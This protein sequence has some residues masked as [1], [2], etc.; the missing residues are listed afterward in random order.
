MQSDTIAA[1]STAF[2]EAAISL[3]RISGPLA[4]KVADEVFRSR[5]TLADLPARVQHFGSVVSPDGAVVDSVLATVFRGPAS[6]TGED[7]VEISCH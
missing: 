5:Q 2:G 4:V 3:L 6:Y 7:V 1:I